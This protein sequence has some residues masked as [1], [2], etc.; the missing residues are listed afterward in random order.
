MRILLL[1]WSFLA[2]TVFAQ[3]L[4]ADTSAKNVVRIGVLAHLGYESTLQRWLPTADYL[5]ESIPGFSF[6]II[7]LTNDDIDLS[8]T[9]GDIDFVL[10]NPA[11]YAMLEV[12]YGVRRLVTLLNP[13]NGGTQSLFGAVI[14]T[15]AGRDDIQRI[16]DLKDKR[17]MA[18]H[19]KA[20]GGWWM[21]KQEMLRHGLNPQ[22]DFASLQFSG[23]P[24]DQVVYAVLDG[25]VDAGTV[26]SSLLEEMHAAGKID[27]QQIK[28]INPQKS[29]Y[30]DQAHSTRLFPEWPF[31]ATRQ[32]DQQLA[33][34]A[35]LALLSMPVGHPAA[36]A[37]Q[38]E[39]WTAPLDYQPVHALMQELRVG[40]Y[41]NYGRVTWTDLVENYLY[42]IVSLIVA[43]L[44]MALTSSFVLGLNNRLS[45]ANRQLEREI[46][47]REELEN[48]LKHQALH[49]ALT[50]L[51]NR[52][53]LLDRLRQAIYTSERERKPFAVAIID[54]DRFKIVNDELGHESGDKL[55]KLVAERFE[56]SV[57]KTDTIAR[58]GGDEFVLLIQ[59]L[60]AA[61][62]AMELVAKFISALDA[63][64]IV[65][66]HE[67]SLGA[68][69]G[70]ASYPDHGH[71]VDTL[72]RHADTAMYRAK[73]D[74][75]G[76]VVYRENKPS[77]STPYAMPASIQAK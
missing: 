47:V 57:R 2:S 60:Q 13:R 20:F 67:Y 45:S 31:S 62:M 27:M 54:L 17:F 59:N 35:A 3:D 19:H 70:I 66:G 55:L 52:N 44:V 21:A 65:G 49:D 56:E 12:R 43:F 16:A 11:S 6:Q 68:S 18:V 41:Q 75:G 72:I 1:C 61:D 14:F 7:P 32:V 37:A 53:L 15:R 26:R 36:H 48:K 69:V 9:N 5:S 39:G 33:Q 76:I 63:P 50:D 38:I 71:T 34:R 51:P 28:V 23:F 73:Q 30:F 77:V 8:V 74:G 4:P 25:K 24:Q 58:F 46:G 29:L 42:W 22:N 10:T 64:F 40:P